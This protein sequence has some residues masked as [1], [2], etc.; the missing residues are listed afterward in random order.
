MR[1]NQ[2]EHNTNFNG[3]LNLKSDTGYVILT[4]LAKRTSTVVTCAKW[5]TM[6]MCVHQTGIHPSTLVLNIYIELS[7]MCN[8]RPVK[9]GGRNLY[10]RRES[11]K[12][13]RPLSDSRMAR[14]WF[15]NETHLFRVVLKSV[16]HCYAHTST[17]GCLITT[18]PWKHVD[19]VCLKCVSWCLDIINCIKINSATVPVNYFVKRS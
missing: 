13:W 18:F 9:H 5:R 10:L 3:S 15:Q 16:I 12:T 7:T 11:H 2:T 17:S 19:D 14:L 1:R 6:N 4:N 8:W